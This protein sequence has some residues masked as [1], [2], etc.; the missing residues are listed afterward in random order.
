MASVA[1]MVI[2]YITLLSCLFRVS[3]ENK[4]HVSHGHFKMVDG[5]S[6]QWI[7]PCLCGSDSH[8][9]EVSDGETTREVAEPFLGERKIIYFK[10]NKIKLLWLSVKASHPIW[11]SVDHSPLSL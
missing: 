9:L 10:G 1:A 11:I 2:F 3:A 5:K 7:L 4:F 6:A 8:H